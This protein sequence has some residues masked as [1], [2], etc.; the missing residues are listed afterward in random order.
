MKEDIA[1][2]KEFEKLKAV[3]SGQKSA[4]EKLQMSDICK[5][6]IIFNLCKFLFLY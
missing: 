3:L 6:A 1:M 4:G 5:Y 2:T